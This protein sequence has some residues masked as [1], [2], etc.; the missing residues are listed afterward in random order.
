MLQAE[1]KA[2]MRLIGSVE[3]RLYY[4]WWAFLDEA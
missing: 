1:V 3:F 2:R 4:F